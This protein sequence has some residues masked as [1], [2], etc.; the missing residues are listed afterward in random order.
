[1]S[2]PN[3]AAKIAAEYDLSR[4]EAM[5]MVRCV[6]DAVV[7][8]ALSPEG[9]SLHG[10][11]TFVIKDYAARKGRNP[12]TGESVAVAPSRKLTFRQAKAVKD[13]LN[14]SG[15]GRKTRASAGKAVAP[16][17][18]SRALAARRGP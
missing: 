1:M 5:A 3:V 13:Q 8:D 14:R 9:V 11:G 17:P 6:L 12:R 16:A 18:K 7:K 2:I 10:F 15:K 4:G